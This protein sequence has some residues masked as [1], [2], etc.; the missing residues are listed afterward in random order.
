[1][2]SV[3]PASYLTCLGKRKQKG[4]LCGVYNRNQ[5]D[6]RCRVRALRAFRWN[7]HILIFG[8]LPN[9]CVRIL[10]KKLED[11][12]NYEDDRPHPEKIFPHVLVYLG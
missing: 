8:K 4:Q 1:M 2:R 3:L 6:L 7:T 12:Q 9:F 10:H 11:F 5:H